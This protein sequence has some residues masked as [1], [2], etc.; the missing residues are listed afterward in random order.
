VYCLVLLPAR[1][2]GRRSPTHHCCCPYT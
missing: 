1:R 2:Q